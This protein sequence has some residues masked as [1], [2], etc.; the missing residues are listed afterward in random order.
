MNILPFVSKE[1]LY[2]INVIIQQLLLQCS[3]FSKV[4]VLCFKLLGAVLLYNLLVQYFG[5]LKNSPILVVQLNPVRSKSQHVKIL[6]L[7]LEFP[8]KI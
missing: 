8:I 6:L 3:N 1:K 5:K 7:S 2:S 4:N